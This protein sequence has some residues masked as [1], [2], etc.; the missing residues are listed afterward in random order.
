VTDVLLPT[1]RRTCRIPRHWFTDCASFDKKKMKSERY[2]LFPH[3]FRLWEPGSLMPGITAGIVIGILAVIVETSLAVLIYGGDLSAYVSRGI[4]FTLLGTALVLV[5][6]AMFSSFPGVVALP[7]NTPAV[8]I[9]LIASAVV[10]GL[11]GETAADRAFA[12]VLFVIVMTSVLTGTSFL[13]M[14]VFNLGRFIRYIPHPVV[15]GFMAGTGWLLVRGGVKVL[16][17]SAPTLG[18]ALLFLQP[19]LLFR[20]LPGMIFALLLLILLRRYRSFL[21]MPALIFA[22]IGIFYLV[23]A[24]IGHSFIDVREQGWLLGPLPVGGL[25]NPPSLDLLSQIHW[26]G[27]GGQM[28]NV[29]IAVVV[30]SLAV[31]MNVSGLELA[32]QRE[33]DLNRELKAAGLANILAGMAGSHPGY[34]AVSFSTLASNMGGSSRLVGCIAALVCGSVLVSGTPVMSFF[35]KPILG[36]LILY[37]GF[38]FLVK[39]LLEAWTRLS[40]LDYLLVVIILFV[41]GTFGFL[42]GVGVGVLAAAL[43]FVV[44]YSRIDVVSRKHTGE[45]IRSNVDRPPEEQRRLRDMGSRMS[46]L[47]LTGFIFFGTAHSLFQRVH[48]RLHDEKLSSLR[49]ILLDFAQ[50][51]GFDGS[52]EIAFTKILRLSGEHN[53]EFVMT[54][55]SPE[56]R[57]RVERCCVQDRTAGTIRFFPDL[58]HGLEWCEEQML[59]TGREKTG[60]MPSSIRD[61]L[62]NL[63]P[64]RDTRINL[65]AYMKRE[66]FEEGAYVIRQD[67]PANGL[68]FLESGELSV[69]LQLE[70]GQ[71][72]RLRTMRPGTVFGEI[73][74]FLKVPRSVSVKAACVS[75]IYRLTE[76]DLLAMKKEVPDLAIE[77]QTYLIGL[78]SQRLVDLNRT[79]LALSA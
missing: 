75:S 22:A 71:H 24:A 26:E 74:L 56:L 78:L 44:K 33:A 20:W 49:F 77:F 61:H 4:G 34:H 1:R 18:T 54:G 9:S 38:S 69:Q 21:L 29:G 68:F 11:T 39:W 46:V 35:P 66:E 25:F 51:S 14:G 52:A 43:I 47:R 19:N 23:H 17:G 45:T 70:G 6:T 50:V 62:R 40:K 8:I 3:P 7:T 37:M 2:S 65:L 64:G 30:S 67:E 5:V 12:T 58:D 79:V 41:I 48:E 42:Q 53:V 28:G 31:L 72:L 73:A 76:E 55:L 36:G 59:H 63:F 16:T 60:N 10:A 27:V 15:G 57:R 32:T 13:L